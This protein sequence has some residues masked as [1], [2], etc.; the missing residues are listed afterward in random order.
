MNS[1][2]YHNENH[3]SL[4]NYI[5]GPFKRSSDY[6]ILNIDGYPQTDLFGHKFLSPNGIWHLG[7]D[8]ATPYSDNTIWDRTKR[9][10]NEKY[11]VVDS[12]SL[13][14]RISTACVIIAAIIACVVAYRAFVLDIIQ[15]YDFK[16]NVINAE[17]NAKCDAC[18]IN[19]S[20]ASTAI[21]GSGGLDTSSVLVD[22]PALSPDCIC[23]CKSVNDPERI[24]A[25]NDYNNSFNSK[26]LLYARLALNIIPGMMVLWSIFKR[27]SVHRNGYKFMDNP[28]D[29]KNWL[30][31]QSKKT[32]RNMFSIFANP[33]VIHV[34]S[35][36]NGTL[37]Q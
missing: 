36:Q 21:T 16:E 35:S 2:E 3:K 37:K 13:L 23:S 8:L 25:L 15:V 24:E 30:L 32:V 1:D 18:K 27:T 31:R 19:P 6:S 22:T 12:T 28:K 9:L 4:E 14:D 7:I 20:P 11:Y 5:E 34:A 29:R 10:F 17:Q 33:N 26:G